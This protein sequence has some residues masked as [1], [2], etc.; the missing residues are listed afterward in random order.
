MSRLKTIYQREL[1]WL[2]S[3]IAR[4]AD[5]LFATFPFDGTEAYISTNID[6]LNDI[7]SLLADAAKLGE[8]LSPGQKEDGKERSQGLRHLLGGVSLDEILNKKVRNT[9]EHFGEYLDR[10]NKAHSGLESADRYFVAYNFI[11]SHWRPVTIPGVPFQ[12]YRTQLLQHPIYPVRVY[13]AA[14]R[15]LYNLDWSVSIDALRAEAESI[16]AALGI[17]FAEEKP[18]NWMSALFVL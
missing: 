2:S 11:F 16:N 15:R 8:L 12:L 3:Q 10:A 1:H 5:R 4:K 14:E 9:I 7:Y 17:Q 6:G 13:V 18:E